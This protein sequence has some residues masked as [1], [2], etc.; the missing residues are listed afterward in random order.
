MAPN[1]EFHQEGKRF[2]VS[3]TRACLAHVKPA[4]RD[5]ARVVHDGLN[6]RISQRSSHEPGMPVRLLL[7]RAEN[8]RCGVAP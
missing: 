5:P 1:E 4:V 8:G 3:G 7:L 2:L 6:D